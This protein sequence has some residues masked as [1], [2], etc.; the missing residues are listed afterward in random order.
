MAK[1]RSQVKATT[2]KHEAHI[3]TCAKTSMKSRTC[4]KVLW[5]TPRAC[6]ID[7]EVQHRKS[8]STPH[9]T[10]KSWLNATHRIF[11]LE[12]T[13]IDIPLARSPNKATIIVSI[14][15]MYHFQFKNSFA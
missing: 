2:I 5:L 8:E 9:R 6:P 7:I 4:L 1:C 14:P 3:E 11:G 10:N 13:T 15:P 12:S